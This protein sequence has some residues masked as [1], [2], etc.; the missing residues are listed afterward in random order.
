M[1]VLLP[2]IAYSESKLFTLGE[3]HV[4]LEWNIMWGLGDCDLIVADWENHAAGTLKKIDED[5]FNSDFSL[6]YSILG[7]L[8]ARYTYIK[9]NKNIDGPIGPDRSYK[10]GDRYSLEYDLEETTYK[11]DGSGSQSISHI[12]S[13][14]YPFTLYKIKKNTFWG[15]K[16]SIPIDI[17]PFIG[18]AFNDFSEMDMYLRTEGFSDWYFMDEHDWYIENRITETTQ[19]LSFGISIP[20]LIQMSLFYTGKD[21]RL[22]FGIGI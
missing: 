21:V 19:Q 2:L 7:K 4:G 12:I 5:F 1:T 20:A 9:I 17:I 14:G 18:I 6:Q 10:Y 15:I 3:T 22:M 16:K 11:Y 8:V 13:L